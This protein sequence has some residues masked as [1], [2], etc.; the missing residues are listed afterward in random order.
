[1]AGVVNIKFRHDYRGAES[2]VEYGNTL[3]KDSGE[4]AASL[5]FGVG[6]D[7]TSV[8]GVLSFYHRNSIFNRDRGYSSNTNS[9]SPSANPVN[10]ALDPN[11]VIAAG[12]PPELVPLPISP[13][14]FSGILPFSLT[15]QPRLPT[16]S[17][18]PFRRFASI[19]TPIQSVAGF[20]TLRRFLEC[21]PQDLRRP[22]GALRRFFLPK[23]AD[24]I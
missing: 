24:Q 16:T 23:R 17:I 4:F 14:L 18:R 5:V 1:M 3:D 9:P 15:V 13:V 10:L 11:V 6:D 8:S 7:K 20:R 19:S 21:R 12:V 22:I 2:D